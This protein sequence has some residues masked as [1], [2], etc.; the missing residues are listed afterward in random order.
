M[1]NKVLLIICDGLSDRPV[2]ELNGKTPLEAAKTPNLDELARKGI[3]GL[4]HTIDVGIRPG[5]DVAHLSLFGYNPY[6]YYSGRGPFEAVGLNMDIKAHDIAFRGN[7]ATVDE[8]LT[9]TDRRAGRI[10]KTH[11]LTESLNK[12]HIKGAHFIVKEGTGHRAAVILRGNNLSGKISDNDPHLIGLRVLDVYSLDNKP[13]SKKTATIENDFLK[14]AYEILLK[15]PL[16][17]E[18]IKKGLPPAN[19]LLLRGAGEMPE[20][21]PFSQKY[22]LKSACIAGAGLYKGIGKMLGMKI[23]NVFGATGKP[24]TDIPAKIKAAVK[25]FNE[26]DFV[27]VHIKGADVLAEDGDCQGKKEFI[28]RIDKALKPVMNLKNTLIVVT[29]DHTTSSELKIH[30]SDPVPVLFSGE[31]VR[32]DE[33]TRFGERTAASGKLGFIK[34][35]HLMR[36][37]LDLLGKAPLYGA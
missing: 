17:L 16:N 11:P 18:R 35:E 31:G 22:G 26:Y 9:I 2:K 28:Q 6:K 20:L 21:T 25:A 32:V 29:A 15:H 37:I 1:L 5:S 19:Y 34:G 27:F 8:M 4:M 24:N 7:F 14:K 36:I 3:T 33:V 13:Q 23:I 10:E 30:T 12:I